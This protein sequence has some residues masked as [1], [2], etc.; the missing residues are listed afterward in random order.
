MIVAFDNTF[1]TL[2]LN[3]GVRLRPNPNTHLPTTHIRQRMAALIDGL[4]TRK[5][6][7]LIPTPALAEVLCTADVNRVL[8]VLDDVGILEL[9]PFDGR[10]AIEL[11]EMTRRAVVGGDKRDGSTADWQKIKLDRQ[12]VAIAKA[13]GASVLYTDDGNQ[14]KFANLG[15]LSTVSTWELDLPAKYAQMDILRLDEDEP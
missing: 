10:S 2:L 11:G 5:D 1:L 14:T 3:P 4:S 13:H 12:I 9:A 6:T 15:G 8:P 7:L